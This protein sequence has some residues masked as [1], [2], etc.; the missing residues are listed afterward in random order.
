[1]RTF[2]LKSVL[3]LQYEFYNRLSKQ[4]QPQLKTKLKQVCQNKENSNITLAIEIVLF[5]LRNQT[6]IPQKHSHK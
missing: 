3:I 2:G 1:M 5:I 6:M 4:N